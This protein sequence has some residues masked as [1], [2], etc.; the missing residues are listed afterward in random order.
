MLSE[1]PFFGTAKNSISLNRLKP[2]NL[3]NVAKPLWGNLFATFLYSK[4]C[5]D[6]KLKI[7]ITG[8]FGG[9]GCLLFL[10]NDWNPYFLEDKLLESK[11]IKPPSHEIDEFWWKGILP[12]VIAYF[13]DWCLNYIPSV[14]LNNHYNLLLTHLLYIDRNQNLHWKQCSFYVSHLHYT[15]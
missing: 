7:A 5:L 14:S 6:R 9:C 1:I 15:L 2:I 3:K 10:C 13:T 12:N 4:Y 11:G 8:N